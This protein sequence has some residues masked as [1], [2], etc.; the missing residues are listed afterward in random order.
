M[1][2]LHNWLIG[3]QNIALSDCMFDHVNRMAVP[4]SNGH[5]KWAF[6]FNK[7]RLAEIGGWIVHQGLHNGWDY[8]AGNL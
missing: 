4:F 2:S 6:T 7:G 8:H 1:R 3:K 5:A